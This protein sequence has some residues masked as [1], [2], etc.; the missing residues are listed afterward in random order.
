MTKKTTAIDS[1][2]RRR[3]LRTGLVTVAA[4]LGLAATL[5]VP[6]RAAEQ[7]QPER[8]ALEKQ[9]EDAQSRLDAAARDVADL[10]AQLY[11]GDA[12]HEVIKFRHGGPRGAML[13][14][15]I[16]GSEQARDEG[17]EVMGVSPSGPA[18]AAGLRKGDVIT[19]VDGKPLRKTDERNAGR[20]LVEYLRSV[21]PG[22]VV[23]VE[24]LR[25]GR[26]QTASVT[27]VAAEPPMVRIM[28]ERIPMLEGVELPFEVDALMG[29]PR[30]AFRSL[31]LVP[32]TPKLGEYF[33]TD[34]GLLVVRAPAA[35]GLEEGDV[36]LTIGGR[37][38][39]DPRHAFR[40]LGSYQPSEQVKVE[41]LR[42]RKRMTV[43]VKLPDHEGAGSRSFRAPRPGV[44]VKP[45][46][47]PAASGRGD[48]VSS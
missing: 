47:P 22:Q 13:G 17:V 28:R 37:T 38:P 16:G 1:R 12:R 48:V 4:L 10:S 9:L 30:R 19:A 27:T 29:G 43:D 14:I 33:G 34:K 25:D 42:H 26:K 24:Y 7:A 40:I 23:K 18:E 46:V 15:N 3:S 2:P 35:A 39:E 45:P 36:I 6:A 5:A 44:P 21:E 8:A 32:I 20:Q 41:V 11:G 31:E